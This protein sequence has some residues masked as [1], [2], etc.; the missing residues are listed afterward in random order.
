MVILFLNW[1]LLIL[2]LVYQRESIIIVEFSDREVYF[3]VVFQSV[4]AVDLIKESL[5]KCADNWFFVV[6]DY[7]LEKLVDEFN[8]EVGEVEASV[9]VAVILVSE[10]KHDFVFLVLVQRIQKLV[11]QPVRQMLDLRVACDQSVEFE[12]YL[13]AHV[14]IG[15]VLVLLGNQDA[16]C[17]WKMLKYEI[18]LR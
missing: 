6:A 12:G 17:K 16:L 2:F 3:Q 13:V 5:G 18:E 10:V 14:Q 8:L 15:N 1:F 7:V 11:D 4:I 9:V